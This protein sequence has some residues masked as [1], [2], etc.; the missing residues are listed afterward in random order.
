M[1][2]FGENEG[3]FLGIVS[4]G[5]DNSVRKMDSVF[6]KDGGKF[7]W[8]GT[9]GDSG[10]AFLKDGREFLGTDGDSGLAFLTQTGQRSGELTANGD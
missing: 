9:D 4:F 1:L 6:R 8:G 3:G 7:F 5:R 10:L 2:I